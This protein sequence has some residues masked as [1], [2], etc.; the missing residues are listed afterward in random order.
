MEE[1]F[2]AVPLLR[3][4]LKSVRMALGCA[5]LDDK[6]HSRLAVDDFDSAAVGTRLLV[7]DAAAVA[8]GTQLGVR[9]S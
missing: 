1:G 6:L 5:G 2:A 3:Q 7:D 9:L 8:H 4:P